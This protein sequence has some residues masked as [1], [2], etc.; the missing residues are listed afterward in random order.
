[1]EYWE[2]ANRREESCWTGSGCRVERGVN[3]EACLEKRESVRIAES[4]VS[5]G[6]MMNLFRCTRRGEMVL[7][8]EIMEMLKL[9]SRNLER[10]R[11]LPK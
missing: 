4:R 10:W 9:D 6:G 7:R 3:L 8:E 2:R 1:M 5:I 11:N